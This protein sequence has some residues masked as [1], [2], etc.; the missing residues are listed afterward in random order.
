MTAEAF[1]QAYADTPYELVHG[2]VVEWQLASSV[3]ASSVALTL[4]SEMLSFV[5]AHSLGM[6]TSAGGAYQLDA[7]TIRSPRVGYFSNAKAAQITDPYR[8]LP[9]APDL[10]VEVISPGDDE[11]DLHDKI[12]S[13]LKA[14]TRLIWVAVL[15]RQEVVVHRPNQPT[16]V[17]ADWDTLS[18]E[19]VL[20][21]F[22]LA[23]ADLF[24]NTGA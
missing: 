14:G 11:A 8:Y 16:Q 9:F 3:R 10:S 21:N 13:Y 17:Y 18:G 12:A 22:V 24:A 15:E 19:D 23:V 4:G 20:P 7:D 1:W 6:V 5:D 2:K